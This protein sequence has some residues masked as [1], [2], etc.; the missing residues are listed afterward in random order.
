MII[1][2]II[3]NLQEQSMPQRHYVKTLIK[4][5]IKQLNEDLSNRLEFRNVTVA[6]DDR[7]ALLQG[8]VETYREKMD[9]ERLARKHHGIEGVR[10]FIAV[11]PVIPVSDQELRETIA[12]RLRYDRVGY[13]ITFNNFEVGVRYGVV[14]ITGDSSSYPDK[15]SALG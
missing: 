12:N 3:N 13:G 1:Y 15:A 8:S 9:A 5:A 2:R 7:V 10:D 14:T 6:V 11:Q 4:S